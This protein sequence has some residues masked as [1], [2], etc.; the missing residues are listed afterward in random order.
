MSVCLTTF[1]KQPTVSHARLATSDMAYSEPIVE[2][3]ALYGAGSLLIFLRL[4]CRWRM[5][6]FRGF[7]P[8]DY[9]V[10]FSWVITPP[11]DI[12]Q[13]ARVGHVPMANVCVQPQTVYTI[14][15][16]AADV[17]DRHADLHELPLAERL[18]MSA[19]EAK[20]YIY[21]R[22][23]FAAGV[24]TYVVFIWS[25]KLNMLFFFRRVV[26]GTTG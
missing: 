22:Q 4:L 12:V 25:L 3:W 19:E 21:V 17:C 16:Y 2:T 11:M 10:V 9:L 13:D 7:D 14:M 6:G 5:V 8:D 24:A 26:K 15:T 1:R 23:W 20:P 18:T